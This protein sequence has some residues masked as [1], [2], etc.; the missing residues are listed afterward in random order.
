MQEIIKSAVETYQCSGCV[1]GSSIKCFNSCPDFK[2]NYACDSH[3][4]GT[5][6]MPHIGTVFLG[7][8]KGFN[9]LGLYKETCDVRTHSLFYYTYYGRGRIP[10]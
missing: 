5:I 2:T 3:V 10:V 1:S 8:P 9:R 6:I 7:L 4:A